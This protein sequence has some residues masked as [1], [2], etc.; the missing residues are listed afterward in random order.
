[1]KVIFKGIR[2]FYTCRLKYYRWNSMMPGICSTII[3][4]GWQGDGAVSMSTLTLFLF[5][6]NNTSFTCLKYN[7]AKWKASF[8]Q[9]PVVS[10]LCWA[11]HSGSTKTWFC[12]QTAHSLAGR[13][14]HLSWVQCSMKEVCFGTFYQLGVI[15][16]IFFWF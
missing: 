5:S 14:V 15:L 1:M 9:H 2:I 10:G 4:V 13:Q 11:G 7:L 3:W 12:G 8:I 16:L 6:W